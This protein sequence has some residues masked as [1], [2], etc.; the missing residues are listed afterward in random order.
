MKAKA[1]MKFS[2]KTKGLDNLRRRIKSA[3]SHVSKVGFW[4]G[5]SN[6][7]EM[8]IAS[9]AFL[10]EYGRPQTAIHN[11]I[12]ARPFFR[13][14]AMNVANGRSDVRHYMKVALQQILSGKQ[15]TQQSLQMVG[16]IY[17][18]EIKAIITY[19][20]EPPNA[21]RTIA[22]KGKDDPL[23]ASGHMRDS[24]QNKV[25]KRGVDV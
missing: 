25:T 12:P 18:E 16:G 13:M 22:M 1:T 3:S 8:S 6:D 14:S 15:T 20:D 7:G 4:N 10:Q 19:F 17:E 5:T 9:L 2:M 11:F 21:A 23:V 24:V